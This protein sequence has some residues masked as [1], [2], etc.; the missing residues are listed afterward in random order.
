[1]AVSI[2]AVYQ[3]VLVIAN[4]E[5]RG[6]ITPQEFNLFANLAQREIFEQYF[7]DVNQFELRTGL[8]NLNKETADL[9]KQ[10][11]DIFYRTF[12]PGQTSQFDRIGNALELPEEIYRV[13]FVSANNVPADYLDPKE[14]STVVNSTYLTRP[15]SI[16]PVYTLRT[17]NRILV[18]TGTPA[19]DNIGLHAYIVPE[20]P[21]WGY[22]VVAGKALHD[23]DPNKTTNFDLHESEQPEL[24]Y[25][26]LKLAGV[27]MKH[28]DI[29]QAGQG[30]EML[31]KNNEKQ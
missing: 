28:Q 26:I 15:S 27:A 2:D 1:M 9:V 8:K 17:N 13:I 24:I 4:K 25:K 18:H 22:F 19:F 31:E 6:Y 12:G 29:L 16:R 30:F 3:Q 21:Q 10:K 7:Y 20:R 14:Y 5:Q 11:L 23:P